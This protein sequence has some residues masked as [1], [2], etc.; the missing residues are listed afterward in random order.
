[1]VTGSQQFSLNLRTT[2]DA[3]PCNCHGQSCY[4][5]YCVEIFSKKYAGI[6]SFVRREESGHPMSALQRCIGKT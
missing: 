6:E 5:R 3:Q 1:M 4:C 2:L